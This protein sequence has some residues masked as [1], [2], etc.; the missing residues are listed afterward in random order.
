MFLTAFIVV[1]ASRRIRFTRSIRWSN[2][3][4]RTGYITVFHRNSGLFIIPTPNLM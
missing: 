2:L 3:C 1:G 4:T